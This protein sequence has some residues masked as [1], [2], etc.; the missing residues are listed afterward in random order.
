[1]HENG[2]SPSIGCI[3]IGNFQMPISIYVL[4]VI[5]CFKPQY[6]HVV[7]RTLGTKLAHYIYM[8]KM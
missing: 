8:E 7:K 3:P 4:Y 1:M 6:K 2:E 5:L